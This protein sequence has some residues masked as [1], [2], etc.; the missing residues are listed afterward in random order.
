MPRPPH[1]LA[2]F[3]LVPVKGNER[4]KRAVA[5]P[6]NIRHV[7]TFSNGREALDVGFHIR[8]RS[9]TTLATLGRGTEADIYLEGSSI[10][11]VQCSF[12]I[13]L[14]TG[15]VM[16]YDRSHG[17]TTQVSG[18]NAMPFERERVQKVLVQKGLNTIIGMGGERRD[19]FN[20]SWNG[21]KILHKRQRPSR[22]TTPCHAVEWRI[23]ASLELWMR[24]QP[25]CHLDGNLDPTRQEL[26]S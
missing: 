10:A 3:S 6:D 11:K 21:I 2:L 25:T 26:Y 14:D 12:E 23:H 5:H 20:S 13:D 22:T 8:G 1:P 4:A 15:V 18:E 9:S 17:C 19:L 24:R 7:S 16:L